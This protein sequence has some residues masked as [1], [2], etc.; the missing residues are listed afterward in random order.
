[1]AEARRELIWAAKARRDL[2]DI[3]KYF[4][5]TAPPE[6]ADKLLRDIRTAAERLRDH[7]FSGRP[8]NEIASDLRSILVHPHAIIYRVTE[9]NV[10]I[11]RIIHERRD[12]AAAFAED[13]KP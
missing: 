12:I 3:W 4:A 8:R 2:I 13:R 7:P 5:R 10:E 6:I 11:A 9:I 1:M